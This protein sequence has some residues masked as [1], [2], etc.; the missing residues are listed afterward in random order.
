MHTNRQTKAN[1]KQQIQTP[2]KTHG[3]QTQTNGNT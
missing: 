3:K 1:N 2:S